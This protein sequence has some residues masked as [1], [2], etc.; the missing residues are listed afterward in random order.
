MSLKIFILR[1][2]RF[3]QIFAGIKNIKDVLRSRKEIK[4]MFLNFK[5][6]EYLSISKE[7]LKT[8]KKAFL[9]FIWYQPKERDL[10]RLFLEC[11]IKP[12]NINEN[13]KK[14]VEPVLICIEKD[15]IERVKILLNHYRNIGIKKFA[16]VDNCSTDG[17]I[18]FLKQQE[19]VDLFICETKYTTLNREAW[20]NRII[21][22]YG[23][24]RWYLCV[25]SDELFVYENCE[26]ININKY[27]EKLEKNK[28][29]RNL[30]LLL[31]M[32]S[33][34]GLFSEN[35]NDI[36][37]EYC[38]FD[39]DTYRLEKNYK[40]EALRGGPRERLFKNYSMEN[41][42]QFLLNKYPLFKFEKGDVQGFSHFQF[43]YY[44]NYDIKCNSV[45]LHYKFLYN[46]FKKYL[47]RIE[48]GNYASGSME[49]KTYIKAYQTGE[50]ICFYDEHSKKYENSKSIKDIIIM[51]GNG[52]N[53]KN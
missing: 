25:D 8:F 28:Q 5:H 17:T 51:N 32:Y 40:F 34:D 2:I 3:L 29:T 11:K 30:S 44:K 47:E 16:I 4:K 14:N 48:L 37:K 39:Y 49:Y 22:Y 53:E 23:F 42:P 27:I 24:D 1:R 52:K 19:D 7:N 12:V 21:A 26:E 43:P 45:L 9:R 38:Y 10:A 33:K 6:E 41:K 18:D 35:K 46:D 31:D 36:Q 15:D 13:N 20:V 50:K